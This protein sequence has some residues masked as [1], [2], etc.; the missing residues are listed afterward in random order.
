MLSK[1]VLAALNDQIQKE[2]A[3]A[4]LYL[5]MAAWF[6]AKN[7]PGQA[8][9]M[10][11]QAREEMEHAMRIYAHVNDCDGRVVLEAIP[12]PAAEFKSVVDVW[13]RTLAHEEKVT[14]SIHALVR[15]AT[16]EG[17][18]PTQAMLQWFVTEQV[19]EEKTARG[20]L[21]QAR[22]L[23]GSDP[24]TFFFDRH[25]GKEAGARE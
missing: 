21:E 17:D 1:K 7:L 5:S 18:L 24:A 10:V 8:A 19:E 22:L 23:R 25:L 14:A 13:E 4:Y 6:E 20:I 11:K 9:W 15:L 3:S 16:A 12:K 2:T